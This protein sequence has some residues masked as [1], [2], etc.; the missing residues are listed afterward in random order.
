MLKIKIAELPVSI[1]TIHPV[2]QVCRSAGVLLSVHRCHSRLARDRD[3]IP[4][5]AHTFPCRVNQN[6]FDKLISFN[7]NWSDI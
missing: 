5:K 1:T 3:N 4:L 7:V 6:S 2:Q